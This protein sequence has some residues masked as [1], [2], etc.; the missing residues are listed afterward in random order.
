MLRN[1]GFGAEQAERIAAAEDFL[2]DSAK[3]DALVVRPGRGTT[4]ALQML[5]RTMGPSTKC[6]K[7]TMSAWTVN[8]QS[9]RAIAAIIAGNSTLKQFHFTFTH[10]AGDRRFPP[11]SE[12]GEDPR[13]R[14]TIRA[15]LT[16]LRRNTSLR[17]LSLDLS[18]F[19]STCCLEIMDTLARH[20]SLEVVIIQPQRYTNVYRLCYELHMSGSLAGLLPQDRP[21]IGG[22]ALPTNLFSDHK[23]RF[24][25]SPHFW[26]EGTSQPL[27]GVF[28]LPSFSLIKILCLN[29]SENIFKFHVNDLLTLYIGSTTT[30]AVLSIDIHENAPEVRAMG[31]VTPE[32]YGMPAGP[33]F[34]FAKELATN[35]SLHKLMLSG[36]TLGDAD[37]FAL[38]H[39]IRTSPRIHEFSFGRPLRCCHRVTEALVEAMAPGFPNENRTL[40]EFHTDV[41]I[42]A[43][44]AWCVVQNAVHRNWTL[45]TLAARFVLGEDDARCAD[46]LQRLTDGTTKADRNPA[47]VARICQLGLLEE[48]HVACS[49]I[50]KRLKV[51]DSMN[52]FMRIVGVV[53]KR[54][55]CHPHPEGRKQ[56]ADLDKYA[57]LALR[58]HLRPSYVRQ[59]S[60][61]A[62]CADAERTADAGVDSDV[63]DADDEATS[64]DAEAAALLAGAGVGADDEEQR[65]CSP[66]KT[67][68][69]SWRFRRLN[70]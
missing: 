12:E 66:K 54:V 30:L 51:L 33:Q 58:R 2:L 46:A 27:E 62:T 35:V 38:A 7:F 34:S 21:N 10:T 64:P 65:L 39:S 43:V 13:D 47:L 23:V 41:C 28:V 37:C 45:A 8:E 49:A 24:N 14:T 67:S 48:D 50:E 61:V 56:L 4:L 20:T 22:T 42:E 70:T 40:I 63:A 1:F 11:M 25:C 69:G 57:W 26:Q 3:I 32:M 53:R 19:N 5:S 36:M 52:G 44:P 18:G 17:Q 16:A 9:L 59:P 68:K 31:Q 29:V 60:T 55:E 6:R 15:L